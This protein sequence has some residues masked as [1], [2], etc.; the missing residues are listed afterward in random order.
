MQ[1]ED[2][3]KKE[4]Q[5]NIDSENLRRKLMENINSLPT[6]QNSGKLAGV[7]QN[8]QNSLRS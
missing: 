6:S 4:K 2:K 1:D 3:K 5:T 8:L 7:L